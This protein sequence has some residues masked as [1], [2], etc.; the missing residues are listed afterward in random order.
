MSGTR[1]GMARPG[2]AR[3]PR[4]PVRIAGGPRPG[5]PG[6]VHDRR[7]VG[8]ADKVPPGKNKAEAPP[9]DTVGERSRVHAPALRRKLTAIATAM[10]VPVATKL[11]GEPA[12]HPP[13]PLPDVQPEAVFAPKPI[14]T[15]ATSRI[16]PA[17][18]PPPLPSARVSQPK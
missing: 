5:G 15:P 3:T 17:A 1:H 13:S 18:R 14:R 4:G 11:A 2:T 9:E 8:G 7:V 6:E 16:A 12:E 10:K